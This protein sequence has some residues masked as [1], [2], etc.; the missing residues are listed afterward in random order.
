MGNEK[1]NITLEKNNLGE[2]KDN[3]KSLVK[4]LK[5]YYI[6]EQKILFA[7]FLRNGNGIFYSRNRT[8]LIDKIINSIYEKAIYRFNI[9]KKDLKKI[10]IVAIGGY[11]RKEM[12]PYSDV[13]LLILHDFEKNNIIKII[14]FVLYVLWDLGFKLGHA[15]RNINECIIE[16]KGNSIVATSL[17]DMRLVAGGYLLFKQLKYLF[18]RE[19]LNN[20]SDYLLEAKISENSNNLPGIMK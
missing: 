7:N 12:A 17:L 10:S 19:I 16:A 13:D 6:A 9:K 15:V 5:D 20:N 2:K 1:T 11:G 14:E 8:I 3:N 4:F 18:N